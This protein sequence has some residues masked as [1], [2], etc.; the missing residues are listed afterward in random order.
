[1]HSVA[2]WLSLSKKMEGIGG[3]DGWRWI[4]IIEGLMT[5]V[6]GIVLPF[7]MWDSPDQASFFSAEEKVYFCRRLR[8]D[9]NTGG[10]DGEKFKWKYVW[11]VGHSTIDRI[12]CRSHL[13]GTVRL[14]DLSL[15]GHLLGQ[16]HYRVWIYLLSAHNRLRFGIFCCKCGKSFGPP[17]NTAAKLCSNS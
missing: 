13:S 14:E 4:F 10:K 9:Y 17:I 3:L 1:V 8:L 7:M 6:L 12:Y 16:H 15:R 2:C 11:Q 5:V